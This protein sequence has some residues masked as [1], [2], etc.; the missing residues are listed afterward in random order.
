MRFVLAKAETLRVSSGAR[1]VEKVGQIFT[2]T[3][4]VVSGG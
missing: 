3:G 1:M 2:I 4:Y